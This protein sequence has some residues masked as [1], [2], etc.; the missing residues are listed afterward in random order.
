MGANAPKTVPLPDR[1]AGNT[2]TLEGQTLEIRGLD[3]S[4]PHRA[5][6]G[7][8]RSRRLPVA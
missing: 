3:D 6:S 1:L 2:L 7:F 8:R 5:T 4:L